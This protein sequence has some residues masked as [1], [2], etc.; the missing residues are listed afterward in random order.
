MRENQ[1]AAD[2]RRKFIK[3]TIWE[4]KMF[5]IRRGVVGW[6]GQACVGGA[7]SDELAWVCS[8]HMRLTRSTVKPAA[9]KQL[10]SLPCLHTS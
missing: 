7:M 5:T 8:F 4:S 1:S 6:L 3:T 9:T 2:K 10:E